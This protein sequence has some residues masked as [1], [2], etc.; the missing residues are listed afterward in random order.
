[1]DLFRESMDLL[2]FDSSVFKR[3]NSWIR[4]V[5]QFSKDLFRGFVSW[6]NFQK[7]HFVDSFC[8]AIFKRFISWI[9]FVRPKIS[10]YSICFV[11]EGFVYKSRILINNSYL[12]ILSI[13]FFCKKSRVTPRATSKSFL[14]ATTSD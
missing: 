6:R 11:S 12:H 7:I 14:D 9:R 3:F 1:M 4:F 10:N 13:F 2:H 5:T 8:D